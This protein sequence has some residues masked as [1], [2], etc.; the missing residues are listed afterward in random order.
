[1][2]LS[3]CERALTTLDATPLS[4]SSAYRAMPRLLLAL[5]VLALSASAR[6]SPWVSSARRWH[7]RPGGAGMLRAHPSAS[8][9]QLR[10]CREQWHTSALDHFAFGHEE[11]FELRY[12]LCDA[13]WR[14]TLDGR[15]GPVFFYAGNEADVTLYVNHS[16]LMWETAPAAGALLLFAEHRYYGQSSPFPP[17]QLK[18][19]PHLMQWLSS[20]QALAD[21]A[22]LLSE[23]KASLNAT[24]S[25]VIAF[26]GS[27]GG[28]LAAWMRIKYPASVDGAIAASAPIWAFEGSTPPPDQGGFA[29]I[30]TRDASEATGA[31][32]ACADNLRAAWRALFSLAET[33]GG[34]DALSST[35]RLCEGS[36]LSDADDA[37]QLAYWLQSA[38]DYLAMGDFP[39]ASDYLTNGEGILPPWP[40]RAAC[41]PLADPSLP[42][43]PADLLSALRDAASVFY[44][45]SGSRGCFDLENVNEATQLDDDYWGYQACTEMVMPMSRDGVRDAFWPQPWDGDAF[46]LEC[47]ARWGVT[48]R[49]GWATVSYGGRK[50]HAAS[51]ILFSN[52]G[53]DPWRAT[54]VT[55]PL[56]RTLV[57]VDIPEGAHHLDLM[58][59]SAD[60][61]PSVRAARDTE[62][63]E[64]SRWLREAYRFQPP[65][66]PGGGDEADGGGRLPPRASQ[67]FLAAAAGACV[68]ACVAAA[69]LLCAAPRLG[70]QGE[71]GGA[72]PQLPLSTGGAGAGERDL[73]E[74][75][76]GESDP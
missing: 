43:R 42:D 16:G 21:Y 58:F 54:G 40:M 30:V 13:H 52:G 53:L 63:R 71:E 31:A 19:L 51:N 41:S 17:E 12:F 70:G 72:S 75:L 45:V 39:Y 36:A 47:Q 34:L 1:M 25:P 27:Y 76:L 56:S 35:F 7:T 68:S 28:M 18:L 22:S 59:S 10:S 73:Q 62:R 46:A 9:E 33:D 26:G 67:L 4:S 5:L 20:E 48:P 44:N 57:A 14:S 32:R 49:P 15:P 38:F 66:G 29:A 3:S 74:P 8:E 24:D 60:D 11:T 2:R 69:V 64:I 61:P 55:R 37:M 6:S 23:V 65:F 50:L